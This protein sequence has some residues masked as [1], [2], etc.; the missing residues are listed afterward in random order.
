M[1]QRDTLKRSIIWGIIKSQILTNTCNSW[2]DGHPNLKR[3]NNEC[4]NFIQQ[5]PQDPPPR[6]P[7]LI[8]ETVNK[9]RN[10]TQW[11]IKALNINQEISN[12][13]REVS[14]TNLETQIGQ[15]YKQ[16]ET[17][18]NWG[19]NGNTLGNPMSDEFERKVE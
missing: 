9:F 6:M 5:A 19:F 15:L 4:Q 8:E 11:N 3:S 16:V 13:N 14:I 18:S 1:Y 17:Q 7:S 2:W 10:I 12:K